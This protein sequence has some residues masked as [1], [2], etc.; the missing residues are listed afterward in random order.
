MQHVVFLRDPQH[1]YIKKQSAEEETLQILLLLLTQT[2]VKMVV[3]SFAKFRAVH[4][5]VLA[6]I[7]QLV[8]RDGVGVSFIRFG[9]IRWPAS[10]GRC[11]S[12]AGLLIV[13]CRNW[14]ACCRVKL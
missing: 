12:G 3:D 8:G 4:E 9:R 13:C 2:V 10:G 5:A 14:R 1:L 7:T 11:A 6:L